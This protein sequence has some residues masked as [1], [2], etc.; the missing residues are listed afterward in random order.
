[1]A[2]SSLSLD[3]GHDPPPDAKPSSGGVSLARNTGHVAPEVPFGSPKGDITH[4]WFQLGRWFDFEFRNALTAPSAEER[5]L[6]RHPQAL[7]QVIRVENVVV[8]HNDQ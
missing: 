2:G 8:V 3:L 6:P 4:V 7:L 5:I 1:S